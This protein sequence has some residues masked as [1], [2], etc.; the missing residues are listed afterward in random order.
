MIL[1]PGRDP[2][3]ATAK[4]VINV[5]GTLRRQL[6]N[7][8]ILLISILPRTGTAYFDSIV[9]INRR[10]RNLHNGQ[11]VFYLDMFDQFR[12]DAWGGMTYYM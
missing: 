7:T 10:I 4:G 5:V 12:G 6:P 9:E 3:H 8:K 1:G 2:D 11:N